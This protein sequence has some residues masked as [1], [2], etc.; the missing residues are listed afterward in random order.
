VWTSKTI[1]Y[2]LRNT[3]ITGCSRRWIGADVKHREHEVIGKIRCRYPTTVLL[4]TIEALKE[5]RGAPRQRRNRQH[6]VREKPKL[7]F[8]FS[9]LSHPV[10]G[11]TSFKLRNI[12]GRPSWQPFLTAV[13]SPHSRGP[14]CAWAVKQA[15]RYPWR[16]SL[17]GRPKLNYTSWRLTSPVLPSYTRLIDQ[18]R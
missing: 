15:I 12:R 3:T 11:L 14:R 16:R 9:P 8:S 18:I 13:K 5:L 4:W 7:N 17:D 2:G 10:T 6:R 1:S